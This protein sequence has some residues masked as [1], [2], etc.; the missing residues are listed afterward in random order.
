MTQLHHGAELM[1]YSTKLSWLDRHVSIKFCGKISAFASKQCPLVPKH[2]KIH[3]KTFAVQGKT[4]EVLAL[5]GF[6]TIYMVL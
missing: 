3:R 6:V 2:F 1:P 4:A 5:K